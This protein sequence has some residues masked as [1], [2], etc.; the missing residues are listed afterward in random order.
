[1]RK[2]VFTLLV[3]AFL[4]YPLLS[5]ARV[6]KKC[7]AFVIAVDESSS[8]N[9]P[10]DERS[11]IDTTKNILLD[12]N[13]LIPNLGY[14]AALLGFNHNTEEE[15]VLKSRVYYPLSNYCKTKYEK[16]IEKLEGTRCLSSLAFGIEQA[17]NIL[18][19]AKGRLVLIIVGDGIDTYLYPVSTKEAVER[20]E[21]ATDHRV[22][23]YAIQVGDSDRGRANL[24]EAV[25]TAGCGKVYTASDMN[26]KAFVRE[27]FGY[28]VKVVKDSDRDGVPDD[29]DACPNT[30]LKAPVDAKGCWHIGMVH[31]AVNSAQISKTYYPLLEEILTV[32][33]ANPS[34]KLEIDGH[35]DSTGP[36][37]YNMKLSIRRAEA[38][39]SW[40]VKHGIS[41]S[42]LITKGFGE[43]RPIA[44]NK[45]PEG[46]AKNRRVE[47]KV[48]K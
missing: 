31:F 25:K 37:S 23:V 19:K 2:V 44:S 41:P 1:M 34:I 17:G 32:L 35:T 43:T 14:K 18:K 11:K 12:I 24:E 30:P 27:V 22:C 8:M 28:V 45:T 39:K 46:R 29:R 40:F 20:L 15:G 13:R 38:V 42:R 16:A 21:K 36:A 26:K 5:S 3:V 4:L 33:K 10:A 9:A 7:D 48:T 47:F 6:I